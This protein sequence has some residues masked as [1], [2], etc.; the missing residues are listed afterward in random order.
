[1]KLWLVKFYE[2]EIPQIINFKR[3]FFHITPI[4]SKEEW[5]EIHRYIV[6]TE[7][8]ADLLVECFNNKGLFRAKKI[9]LVG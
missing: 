1:M 6:D 8:K 3:G 4:Y 2:L 7:E 9:E 5:K